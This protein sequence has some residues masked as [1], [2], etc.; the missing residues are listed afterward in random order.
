MIHAAHIETIVAAFQDLGKASLFSDYGD[1][2][3]DVAVE[4]TNED[5]TRDS[6]I[7]YLENWDGTL[8]WIDFSHRTPLGPVNGSEAVAR[9]KDWAKNNGVS[10]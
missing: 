10:L 8:V 3:I 1:G 6:D 9:I 7:F 4:F 5:G 2:S